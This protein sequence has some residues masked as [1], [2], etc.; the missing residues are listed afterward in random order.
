[1]GVHQLL[2]PRLLQCS[3][4]DQGRY[5]DQNSVYSDTCPLITAKVPYFNADLQIT[6]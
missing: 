4:D 3:A 5:V 2:R 6:T 1:M